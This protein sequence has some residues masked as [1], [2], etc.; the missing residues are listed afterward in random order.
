[1]FRS[2]LSKSNNSRDSSGRQNYSKLRVVKMSHSRKGFRLP[3]VADRF[4]KVVKVHVSPREDAVPFSFSGL[5][6]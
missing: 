4:L 2:E 5:T 6:W 3:E 1:M